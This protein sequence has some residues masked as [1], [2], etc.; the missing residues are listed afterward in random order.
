MS[1]PADHPWWRPAK[2]LIDREDH[3]VVSSLEL[4]Y[5]LVYVALIAELSGKLAE[6]VTPVGLLQF[7]FLFMLLWLAWFNGAIYHDLHGQRDLRTR[8]Y[9]F[10]QMFTV[11]GM[12]SFAAE[13]FGEGGPGFALSFCAYQL[14][15]TSLWFHTGIADP[16]HR[17]L[18]LPYSIVFLCSSLIFGASALVEPSLRLWMW[19]AGLSL[20]LGALTNTML[21]R[22]ADPAVRE[23]W[24]RS[25]EFSASAVER[26]GLLVI[27]VLGEVIVGLVHGLTGHHGVSLLLGATG[28]LGLFLAVGLWWLYF[29]MV[30]ERRPIARPFRA[31][32]WV[33]LHLSLTGSIVAC[34]AGLATVLHQMGQPLE[35]GPRWLLVGAAATALLSVAGLLHTVRLPED[36]RPLYRRASR[37]VLA[38]AGVVAALGLAPLHVVPLLAAMLA[39]LLVPVVWGTVVWIRHFDAREIPRH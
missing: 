36:Q 18:S 17:P 33:N 1:N 13:A 31:F 34:G 7:A 35:A 39:A 9:T 23:Q 21:R 14:I 28:A 26:F 32:A 3:R 25:L 11:V 19:I 30:S 24:E 38:T 27:V 6:H 20:T 4:F 22:P 16:L 29:D 2:R 12:A 15:L 10:L 37:L 5:D 8:Y